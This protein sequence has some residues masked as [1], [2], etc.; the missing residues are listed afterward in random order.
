MAT[1]YSGWVAGDD[2]RVRL[3]Y[4]VS[5]PNATQAKVT[6]TAYIDSNYGYVGG[7]TVY[8][9]LSCDGQSAQLTRSGMPS[10]A[11]TNMGSRSF[12]VSR[13]S[14]DRN[15]SVS[16]R[17]YCP[18]ASPYASGATASASTTIAHIAWS[19]PAAPSGCSA[20]RASDALVNVSWSNG[21]TTT[22]T[23]RSA[24][25]V[26]RSVDGGPWAQVASLGSSATSY[27]DSGVSANHRYQYRV[28]SQ[29]AGG[30]SGY[31]TS[32]YVRT[33]PS[34]PTGCAAARVSDSSQTVTWRLG[35]NASLTWLGVLVERSV[36]GGSW[37]Q[38]A[39]LSASSTSWTD[40]TTAA[41]HRYQYRVRS[42][43]ASSG[44]LPSSYS[45]SGYVHTT[46]APPSA[47]STATEGTTV[48]VTPSGMGRWAEEWDLERSTDGGGSWERLA[49]GLPATQASY[50]DSLSGSAVYRA[51]CRVGSLS[52]SWAQS[53]AVT[54]IVVPAAPTTTSPSDG[55]VVDS[56]GAAALS[57]AHNPLDGSGQ[58]RAEVQVSQDGGQW[59]TIE[60]DGASQTLSIDLDDYDGGRVLWRVRTWGSHADPSPWSSTSSFLAYAPPSVAVSCDDTLERFPFEVAWSYEDRD[61]T[62]ASA[63]VELSV[64]GSPVLELRASDVHSVTVRESDVALPTGTT[65]VVTLTATSTTGLSSTATSSFSVSYL[66]PG[67]PSIE[68]SVDRGALLV[69]VAVGAWPEDDGHL[70]TSGIDVYRGETLVASGLSGGGSVTDY[71][72]PLDVGLTYRAVALSS[73]G[74]S[75]SSEATATV[76]SSGAVAVNHGPSLSRVAVLPFDVEVS[77]TE[78]SEREEFEAAAYETPVVAYGPHRTREGSARG[79]CDG[80]L[81]AQSS[82]GSWVSALRATGEHSVRLPGGDLFPASVEGELS[83]TGELTA[84]S[85]GLSVSWRE[86]ARDGLL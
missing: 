32:G 62:Q 84:D 77:E 75:A 68:L 57:W 14:S 58:T 28:R 18:S 63:T 79:T 85:F 53:R 35:S 30:S 71:V 82:R 76:P 7:W 21:S 17:I 42:Y 25:L 56:T 73:V 86:A 45:T 11:L 83:R 61:G 40:T 67:E 3:D 31:S 26:E 37:A 60:V 29:G 64:S 5:Y 20:S 44:G 13:G 1:V 12:T 9:A 59:E 8:A 54:T 2:Y 51:R 72:P 33:T 48:T 47:V 43:A 16:C 23:P 38:V 24:V 80:A 46:P 49:S 55:S 6:L 41:D 65:V 70:A 66:Q 10:H 52:S 69:T 36:D 27:G 4:S 39:S 34:A 19:A 74:S 81:R 15:I 22:T 50:S 78:S